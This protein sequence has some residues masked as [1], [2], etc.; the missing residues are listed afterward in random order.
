MAKA[1]QIVKAA[2]GIW[3]CVG[4]SLCGGLTCLLGMS[5]ASRDAHAAKHLRA[6]HRFADDGEGTDDG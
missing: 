5:L 2:E 3:E 6:G 1:V 4:C